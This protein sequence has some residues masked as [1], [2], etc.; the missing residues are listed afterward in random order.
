MP[1]S[2][3]ELFEAAIEATTT[4][5]PTNHVFTKQPPEC[6]QANPDTSNLVPETFNSVNCNLQRADS[7]TPQH[8]DDELIFRKYPHSDVSICSINIGS[9]KI[10][11][12]KDKYTHEEMH[13]ALENGDVLYMEGQCQ[14]YCTHE[15][16]ANPTSPTQYP[17]VYGH[18]TPPDF[19]SFGGRRLN[20]TGRYIARHNLDCTCSETNALQVA[21]H[22]KSFQEQLADKE[23]DYFPKQSADQ[24]QEMHP[25]RQLSGVSTPVPADPDL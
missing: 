3:K 9:T 11:A 24:I 17:N 14:K 2:V 12:L 7:F 6:Q 21:W 5:P 20:L 15:A 13:M 8:S 1:N 18:P 22:A 25:I 4:N 23:S 10:F 19:A 16:F